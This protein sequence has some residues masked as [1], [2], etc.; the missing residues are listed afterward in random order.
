MPDEATT[1]VIRVIDL[2]IL[3]KGMFDPTQWG[4]V[5]PR[6]VE[7]M[8]EVLRLLHRVSEGRASLLDVPRVL[9]DTDFVDS[10][11]G[12][13]A[14]PDADLQAWLKAEKLTRRSSEFGE[15]NA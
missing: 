14:V 8:T 2:R 1:N 15:L 3:G 11:A 10:L 5:G 6:F 9:R 13:L 7:R 4:I 12:S